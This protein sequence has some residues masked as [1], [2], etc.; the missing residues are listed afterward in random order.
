[1]GNDHNAA[2]RA[3]LKQVAV[4]L[5]MAPLGLARSP[6]AHGAELALL[7]EQD[8]AAKA[9]HYVEDASRAKA[10]ASGAD[11]SNCSIYGASGP[12]RGSCTLFP[13]K[14]VKAAG[15]CSSWSGL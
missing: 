4:G 15:W 11:C 7:S 9:V 2:R 10:A 14:L 6:A 1:M 8:A 5:A 12:A 13:G 3:M